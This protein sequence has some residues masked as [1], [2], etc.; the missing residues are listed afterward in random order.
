MLFIY[1]YVS[2]AYIREFLGGRSYELHRIT[3]VILSAVSSFP[4]GV[5]RRSYPVSNLEQAFFQQKVC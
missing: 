4:Y 5:I 3:T 2:Y 1:A